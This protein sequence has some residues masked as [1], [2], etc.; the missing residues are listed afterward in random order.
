MLVL[1]KS[2]PEHAANAPFV[3][4]RC[5][6]VGEAAHIFDVEELEDVVDAGYDLDVRL[7]IIHSMRGV[8]VRAVGVEV[9]GEVE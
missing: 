5:V 1:L 8:C 2:Y 7:F 6:G 4:V 9:S 3:Y